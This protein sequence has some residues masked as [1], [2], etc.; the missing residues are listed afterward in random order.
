MA[1]LIVVTLI[2]TVH[3]P[4]IM[5]RIDIGAIVAYLVWRQY[6]SRKRFHISL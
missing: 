2:S 6:R 4:E 5:V 1:T 3:F